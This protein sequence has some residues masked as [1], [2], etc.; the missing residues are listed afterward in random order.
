M[1]AL[2]A[3]QAHFQGYVWKH[4]LSMLMGLMLQEGRPTLT[5]LQASESVATLSRTLNRYPWPLQQ[6]IAW[7]QRRITQGLQQRFRHQRGRRPTVYLIVDD[8][9]VE[10][11]GKKLPKL[12]YHFA[13]SLDKV[14]RGWDLVFAAVRVGQVTVPWT[15]RCYVNERFCEE[16]SFQKRTQLAVELI[17]TFVP[18]LASPVVVLVDSTYCSAPVI[19]AATAR[20]FT[21]VGWVR[22]DRLLADERKAWDVD[23]ETIGPLRGMTQ[24]IKVVHRGR[25]QGRRTVISTELGW[26]RAM[27]LRH[28]KSR[29]GIEVMFRILKEEFGLGACRCRGETSLARWV[30]LVLWA[31]V[32]VALTRWGRRLKSP[33]HRWR[34]VRTVWGRQLMEAVS[35]VRGWLATLVWVMASLLS[36]LDPSTGELA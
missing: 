20:G 7:R 34:A 3:L 16:E 24:P 21:V 22:K 26:G 36:F 9:V 12:G 35:D 14:V 5:A 32:L 13:S 10:K 33:Q 6:M 18:P 31:Y 4:V 30:E 17:G 29:W 8:T 25:G 11:R 2:E 1:R 28:L 27:I 23:E 15:W 19:E